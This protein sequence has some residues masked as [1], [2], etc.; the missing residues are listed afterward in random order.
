MNVTEDVYSSEIKQHLTKA[1]ESLSKALCLTT[2]I[3]AAA[4]IANAMEQVEKI[5]DRYLGQ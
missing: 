5:R 2:S 1:S 4:A 3:A